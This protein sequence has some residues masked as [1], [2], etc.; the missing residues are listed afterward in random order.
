MQAIIR[1][2]QGQFGQ[3][4]MMTTTKSLVDSGVQRGFAGKNYNKSMLFC[5]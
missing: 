3:N 2:Q 5:F 1:E 4:S